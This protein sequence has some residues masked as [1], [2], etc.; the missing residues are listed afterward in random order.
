MALLGRD[1]RAF[2]TNYPLWCGYPRADIYHLGQQA[3][4]SLLLV[5]RPKGKVVVKLNLRNL[6]RPN[7]FYLAH[8]HPGTC[9]EGETHEH[10]GAHGAEGHGH[11]HG[12]E[13]EHGHVHG[14]GCDHAH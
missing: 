7:T 10:G 4:T 11:E 6:P 8:I 3:L 12:H 2:L 9:A 5:R 14:P 13:H 1:L